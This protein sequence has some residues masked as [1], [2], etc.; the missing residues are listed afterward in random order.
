MSVF[1]WLLVTFDEIKVLSIYVDGFIDMM[2]C[3]TCSGLYSGYNFNEIKT[4]MAS[5]MRLSKL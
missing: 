1:L 3:M 4:G 2:K 5:E